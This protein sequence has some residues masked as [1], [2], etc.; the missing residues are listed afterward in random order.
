LDDRYNASLRPWLYKSAA[1]MDHTEDDRGPS[2]PM[3][4]LSHGNLAR[5]QPQDSLDRVAEVG[6]IS[7]SQ[8]GSNPGGTLG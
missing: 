8:F 2:G 3:S 5:R 1:Y 6:L 4:G 7:E